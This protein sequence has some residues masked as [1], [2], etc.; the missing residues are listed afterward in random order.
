MISGIDATT[1][2]GLHSPAQGQALSEEQTT[3][4]QDIISKYDPNTMTQAD[5]DAMRQEFKD[6]G[7][8]PSRE[9]GQVLRSAGFGPPPGAGMQGPPPGG[10]GGPPPQGITEESQSLLDY[11]EKLESDEAT[12]EDIQIFLESMQSQGLISQGLVVDELL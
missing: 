1:L 5:H 2:S 6:A 3:Q 9:V 7:I 8:H 10:T 11:L 4:L 12:E